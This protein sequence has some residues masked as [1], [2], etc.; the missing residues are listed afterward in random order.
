MFNTLVKRLFSSGKEQPNYFY[1]E[2][3]K[4]S[5]KD[6]QENEIAQLQ[7]NLN[8]TAIDQ[9]NEQQH[10]IA[11]YDYLFGQSPP[12]RQHDELSLYVANKI[13]ELM[14]QPKPVLASLPILPASLSNVL[15]QLDNEDFHTDTLI[16]LIELE[17]AIAA[18]VIELANS[19]Y[20][21]H[22]E[23]EVT[24][25]KSAFMLLGVNGLIEGVINGFVSKLTPRPQVYFSQYGNKIW[26][27]SLS[28]GVI[29]KELL[30]TSPLKKQTAQGYL[31]GLIC[32]LG[33]MI[34]YQ[35]LTEAFAYIHPDCQPNSYAFKTLMHENSTKLTYFIAKHW[36]FP[37]MILSVLALQTK[38]TKAATLPLLYQKNPMACYIYEANLLSELIIRYQHQAIDSSYLEQA[39]D[40]LIY[41]EQAKCYLTKAIE[42]QD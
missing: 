26:Q 6:E 4:N 9:V 36:H 30:H 41:S 28:T 27:H 16:K 21:N 15:S 38:I 13:T 18:K 33:D 14:A 22:S 19:S 2:D 37:E 1:Y 35:L 39:K 25:L 10:Q 23:K 5:A 17:P 20:Y 24:E 12:T 7:S 3:T 29:A 11:F 34:I 8:I 40:R 32:N 31:L 42:E